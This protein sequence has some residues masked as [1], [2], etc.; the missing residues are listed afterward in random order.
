MKSADTQ[1]VHSDSV[2]ADTAQTSTSRRGRSAVS[3]TIGL[4]LIGLCLIGLFMSPT[5]SVAGGWTLGLMLVLMFLG[6]PIGIALAVPSLVGIYAVSGTSAAINI[7]SVAPYNTVSSWS[8]SVLPMFIFMAMLLAKSGLIERIYTAAHQWFKWLPGGIGVGTTAAGAGLAS[9]SGSTIG[10]TYALGKAGIPEMLKAGYE[11]RIAVGT[12]IIAGLPGALI[13]PSILLVIYASIASVPVGPQLV[14]GAVPGILIAVTFGVFLAALGLIAPRL[15]GRSKSA[16]SVTDDKAAQWKARIKSLQ[17]VWSIPLILV[18]LFGGLFSGAFTPTE[19]GA[20]GA[21][22]A[23]LLTIWHTRGQKPLK[24]VGE[25]AVASISATA[26]IFF[27]MIGAEMLTR[28]LAL[29]GLARLLTEVVVDIG[30]SRVAFLLLLIPFYI[31]LGMFFDT[32]SMLLLTVPILL[33][34]LEVMGVSPLWFG[35]FVVLLGEIGMI[36]PPVGILSYIIYNIARDPEVNQGHNIRL[37]DVFTSLLWFLPVA[38][39]F[40]VLLI[41]FP[42]MT[43]WLPALLA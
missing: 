32:L 22:T 19:A 26:A 4:G 33:P 18:V 34:T 2:E 6:V 14:A 38:V 23:L 17:A 16:R 20:A 5:V 11:K 9:V 12:V 24:K 39:I 29:T 37:N 42:Q 36:T 25:A 3:R 21:M 31:V 35:V 43:E 41:M 28:M 7:V 30:L 13:P 1:K 27:V 8:M 10:M 15:V 40:L